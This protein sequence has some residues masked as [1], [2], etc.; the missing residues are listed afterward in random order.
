MQPGHIGIPSVHGTQQSPG[1]PD[2]DPRC[3]H[4][5]AWST[6]YTMKRQ[7]GSRKKACMGTHAP[8]AGASPQRQGFINRDGY[9]MPE[10]QYL[11]IPIISRVGKVVRARLQS[12]A[13]EAS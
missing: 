13:W 4:V 11:A 1:Q 6:G 8:G 2:F 12:P 10:W 5:G 3:Y 9:L 7:P